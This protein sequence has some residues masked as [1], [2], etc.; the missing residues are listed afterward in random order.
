[1]I[2]RNTR[3]PRAVSWLMIISSPRWSF[4]G[5]LLACVT[6]LL[7]A[8]TDHQARLISA[9]GIARAGSDL[10]IVG[11][12][13]PAMLFRYRMQAD[14]W[15]SGDGPLLAEI[16]ISWVSVERF[17]GTGAVDLEGVDV[18][19]DGR[20]VVL[21]ETL[22]ALIARDSLVSIYPDPM[23]EIGGRGMEGVAVRGDGQ[24]AGLWEGGY[25]SPE[26]LP[27]WI[28]GAGK[29]QGGP[30][31]AL[32][33]VHALP[34]D[35]ET[36]VCRRGDGVVVLQVPATPDSTQAFRA[37]DLVWGEDGQS[38]IV[39]LSSTNAGTSVFRYKWLQRFST[40]GA[41][42]GDPINL[43]ASGY[44]PDRVRSGK[45]GNFEGLGWFEPG[46]S[47]VLIN[48]YSGAA[49]AVIIAIDLWQ[50]NDATIACDEPL[51]AADK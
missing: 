28:A 45:A 23:G 42:I 48:D 6:S 43:C 41:A 33:C 34:A 39:L 37:T 32:L 30:M 12:D 44:L 17:G 24:V 26:Y 1:M 25:F 10:V 21:S 9:S 13:T 20:I 49:T 40:S 46:K 51:A 36:E 4:V 47:L 35:A 19:Q 27:T 22:K 16:E 18:L 31:K 7:L 5:I 29:I 14:D 11:D 2:Y 50:P 8:A 15:P 3:G 38:I